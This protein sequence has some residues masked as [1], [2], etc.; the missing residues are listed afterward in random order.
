MAQGIKGAS[1][2]KLRISEKITLPML[3][4]AT[5]IKYSSLNQSQVS[6]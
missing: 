5:G 1:V 2:L 6:T 4:N 3:K